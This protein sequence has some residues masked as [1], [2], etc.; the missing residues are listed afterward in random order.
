[1]VNSIP[2][3][4]IIFD[5]RSLKEFSKLSFSKYLLKDVLVALNKSILDCKIEAAINWAIELLLSGHITKFWDRVIT[6]GIKNININNPNICY[7]LYVK[8]SKHIELINK[9]NILNIRNNQCYRNLIGEVCFI[10]CNS[11]KTKSLTFMK[12]KETD[13]NMHYLE[14]KTQANKPDIINDKLKYGDPNE[15]KIILNEFNY[16]LIN[17]KYELCVYWL[18]WIFEWEK[19][20]TKKNKMYICGYREINNV[21]NKYYNDLVWLIWEIILKEGVKTN[22]DFLNNQIQALYKLYK[23]DF[24]Q[25]NKSK[26]SI[27]FL[28]AIKYF[29]DNYHINIVIPNYHLLIQVCLNINKMFFEKIKYSIN[30]CKNKEIYKFNSNVNIL[31]QEVKTKET[32]KSLS[33]SKKKM[34]EIKKIAETKMKLKI[35]KLEEIDS[36]ILNKTL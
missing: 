27:Y 31:K 14:S 25:S 22:N 6:I 1:M 7:F 36:L 12:I 15:T 17:K 30:N 9:Y 16:C 13:F 19:K 23:F 11:L 5:N 29:T 35:T 18:S 34:N 28:L 24:K 26:K 32:T 21:D 3:E 20:N 2:N 8:Y 10:I 4:Y 33:E